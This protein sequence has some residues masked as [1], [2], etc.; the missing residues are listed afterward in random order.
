[1]LGPLLISIYV[2]VLSM[3]VGFEVIGKVAPTLHN[4]LIAGMSAVAGVSLLATLY[5]AHYSAS[6]SDLGRWLAA[7]SALLAALNLVAG[8]VLTS[9]MLSTTKKR[10][11]T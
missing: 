4:A 1:M 8:F 2:F 10:E 6:A 5:A 9:R 11:R 7:V 3:F